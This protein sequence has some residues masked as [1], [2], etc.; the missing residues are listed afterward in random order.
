MYGGLAMMP[1]AC[2]SSGEGD[3]DGD[4]IQLQWLQ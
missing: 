3:G 1:Y 2:N 4:T